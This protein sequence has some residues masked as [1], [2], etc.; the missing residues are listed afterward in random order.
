MGF[1]PSPYLSLSGKVF[2]SPS[3]SGLRSNLLTQTMLGTLKKAASSATRSMSCLPE[4]VGSVTIRTAVA[5]PRDAITGQ[6]I[7]GGPSVRSK[8]RLFFF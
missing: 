1:D 8:L 3:W 2:D 6:P 5:P 4:T 7:P